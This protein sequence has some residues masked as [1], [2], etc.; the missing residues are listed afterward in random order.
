MYRYTAPVVGRLI[1]MSTNEKINVAGLSKQ[2]GFRKGVVAF[3]FPSMP[4]TI[5]LARSADYYTNYS[6]VMPDGMHQY[7]GTK[8]LEIP[9]TF[10]LHAMDSSFCPR[11]S[12]TLLQLA[13]RLHSFVL[14]IAGDGSSNVQAQPLLAREYLNGAQ[15][16]EERATRLQQLGNLKSEDDQFYDTTLN[17][18]VHRLTSNGVAVMP[19]P[20][21]TCLLNLIWV[22]ENQPGIACVGYVRD[23]RVRLLGPWLQGPTGESNLPSAG[24]YE[25]T[26]IH[27]PAHN[28]MSGLDFNKDTGQFAALSAATESQAY[29]TDVRNQLYNT[30]N[31]VVASRYQGFTANANTVPA[32]PKGGGAS[33][34]WGEAAPLNKV[35]DGQRYLGSTGKSTI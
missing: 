30:R 34:S 33:G 4:D 14:P 15:T 21:V 20:P 18:P 3:D 23:V 29:A 12:L 28:N 10:K 1:A 16:K 8:P 22:A 9:L 24:E 25:F 17:T 31:L 5:E 2:S 7:R 26:F 27:R 35:V 32:V 13:A 11:G 19:Y 6:P